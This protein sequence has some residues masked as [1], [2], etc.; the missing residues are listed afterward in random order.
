MI[1]KYSDVII[2]ILDNFSTKKVNAKNLNQ[3]IDL[4]SDLLTTTKQEE[5]RLR[6][7]FIQREEKGSTILGKK[8][9]MLLHCRAEIKQ[10]ISVKVIQLINPIV[11]EDGETLIS[12]VVIMVG[13]EEFDSAIIEVMSAV[14][15]SII[16]GEFLESILSGDTED[17]YRNLNNVLDQYVKG[18]IN[19]VS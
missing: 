9:V 15:R 5:E 16:S 19:G 17:M 12:S 7:A 8:G 10:N 4:A 14:S 2:T 11:A 3:V 1:N 13:P 6:K 18:I